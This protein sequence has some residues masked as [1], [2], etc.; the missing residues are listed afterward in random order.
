MS[1]DT[2]HLPR[3]TTPPD[4][5]TA[6][7]LRV[8]DVIEADLLSRIGASRTAGGARSILPTSATMLDVVPSTG[9]REVL[10]DRPS[11]STDLDRVV[12]PPCVDGSSSARGGRSR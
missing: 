2:A 9:E 10:A 6:E 8:D 3:R 1:I 11:P 5:L 4:H 12:P 7:R